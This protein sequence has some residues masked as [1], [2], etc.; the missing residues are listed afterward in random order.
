M[1]FV[2]VLEDF[3]L[4]VVT[5]GF[6]NR[7]PKNASPRGRNSYLTGLGPDGGAVPAKRRGATTVN[8]SNGRVGA[9]SI[10]GQYQ[11]KELSSGTFTRRHVL[12]G[13][14]GQLGTIA[15]DPGGTGTYTS[16]TTGLTASARPA[17]ATANNLCFLVNGTDRK[18]LRGATLEE[19]GID[20]PATAPTLAAGAAGTPSGTY[21]SRVTFVNGNTGAESSAGPTS[22]TVTVSSQKISFTSI[23]TSA[24]T[25]VTKRNIYLRNTSTQANFYLAATIADNSTTTLTYDQADTLLVTLGPDTDENDRPPSGVRYLSWHR[26]RMF[27]ADDTKLYYSKPEK[28]EAF[29]ADNYEPVGAQDGQRITGLISYGDVLL[30]FK[31]RSL[32]GLF[33]VDPTTW[34]VRL[35]SPDVGCVSHWSIVAADT[36]LYWWS[37]QGPMSMTG[38]AKPENIGRIFLGGTVGNDI[39]AYG[40]LGNIVATVDPNEQHVIWAVADLGETRNTRLLVFSYRLGRWVTDGWTGLDAASLATVEDDTG[41]L[42]VYLGNYNGQV[43]RLWDADI[44]AVPGGTTTGTFTAGSSSITTITSS[45]FYTTGQALAERYVTVV[46]STGAL[47]GQ[48]R[49]SSN[50]A[51]TLTLASA[52]SVTSGTTYT[53]YIGGPA[54]EW[55][56]RDEDSGAPFH[57]KRYRYIH[58]Q[59]AEDSATLGLDVYVNF[60]NTSS[61][62]ISY[63]INSSTQSTITTRKVVGKVG[64]SWRAR[65]YNY[66][67]NAPITLYQVGMSGASETTKLG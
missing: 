65:L 27:A 43:W 62:T 21:E 32:Y 9:V 53:F 11:Y 59:T 34:Q 47:V 35:L 50:T 29:D 10:L 37:D 8:A 44:D 49:I 20:A 15:S 24:D 42:W 3:S 31:D 6:E 63:S 13:S 41:R 58:V 28:P 38:V 60:N 36:S 1:R 57:K 26:F 52:L 22:S 39:L 16:I 48:R 4:G 66:A 19:F 40:Q 54:W 18:K 56:T 17:F 2:D 33:G 55:D 7:I 45:G 51:T 5:S 25:Q 67:P 64:V 14:G 12:A 61:T 30:I 46:T 23:P